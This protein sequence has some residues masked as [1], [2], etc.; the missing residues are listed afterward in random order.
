M[1]EPFTSSPSNPSPRRLRA[2]LPRASL[3]KAV[4][5]GFTL[6]CLVVFIFG[7]PGRPANL[8]TGGARGADL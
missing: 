6:G 3:F 5:A 1:F 7:C 4:R 8:F 2:R